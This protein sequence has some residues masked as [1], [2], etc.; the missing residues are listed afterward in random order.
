VRIGIIG[1]GFSGIG[2]A[3]RLRAAGFTN[4]TLLDRADE[5]GGTWRDNTYPGCACDVRSH[6]YSFSFAPNPDWSRAYPGQAEIQAYLLRCVD[7]HGLRPDIVFG[8]DVREARWDD[9]SA[10]WEVRTA[11]GRDFEFDALISAT[12]PLSRPAVPDIPG[13]DSFAGTVFHTARWNHDHDLSGERV[14]VVGTGASAIQVVPEL[15]SRVAHLDVFQR[16]PPWIVARDDAPISASRR[17]RYARHPITARLH[18]TAIYLGNELLGTAFRGNERIGRRVRAAA[19][20]HLAA[21]VPDPTLRAT[22]TPDYAP[23]CKRLLSNNDWYP[24][25]Q[26]PNVSLVS[27]GIDHVESGSIVTADGIAHDVDTIVLATGFAATEFLAPMRV[28]GRGGRELSEEWR[29]G[30]ATYLGLAA[31]GFPNFWMLVGPSTGLGHNS[32]VF[33]IESQLHLVVGALR[34]MV[35]GRARTVEVRAGAQRRAYAAL[36]RRMQRTVWASGCRSWYLNAD[37]RND[38]LWPGSTVEYWARTRRFPRRA[39][40]VA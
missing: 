26:R 9:A 14:A 20:E 8:A 30:A 34:A 25:L 18:R 24:A 13:L 6:L 10:S 33:M 32:I 39:F 21:Q 7:D 17:R 27:S 35:S 4:L 23:G 38:T 3:I 12:G 31:H 15:V 28:H 22:L 1:T 36:Q 19:E 16:T 37:G 2:A 40:D 11:D 29:N 5:I